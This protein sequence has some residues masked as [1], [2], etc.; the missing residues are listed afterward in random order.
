MYLMYQK[1]MFYDTSTTKISTDCK[2]TPRHYSL[3]IGSGAVVLAATGLLDGRRGTT[4][5]RYAETLLKRVPAVK[6]DETSVYHCENNICTS[7]ESAAGID[8]MIEL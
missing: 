2:T 3:P 6:V 8:L 5:L 4:H 1:C 7:A